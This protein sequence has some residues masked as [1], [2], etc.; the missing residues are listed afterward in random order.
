MRLDKILLLCY[1][2]ANFPKCPD[3]S[4]SDFHGC[5]GKIRFRHAVLLDQEQ[6]MQFSAV[7]Y[8]ATFVNCGIWVLYGLLFVHPHS[9]LVVTINV[10]AFFIETPYLILFLFYSAPKQRL[11]VLLIMVAELVFLGVLATLT[12]TVAHTTKVRSNIVGSIAIVGNIMMYAAPLSVMLKT[13]RRI[14]TKL[15]FKNN[16]FKSTRLLMENKRIGE[17]LDSG[18]FLLWS[19]VFLS[20]EKDNLTTRKGNMSRRLSNVL[21]MTPHQKKSWTVLIQVV[22]NVHVQMSH[23]GKRYKRLISTDTQGMT[24]AT[25]LPLLLLFRHRTRRTDDGCGVMRRTEVVVVA[26]WGGQRRSLFPGE[27]RRLRLDEEDNIG[28]LRVVESSPNWYISPSKACVLLEPSDINENSSLHSDEVK[29]TK[30][31]AMTALCPYKMSG[32]RDYVINGNMYSQH[33]VESAPQT[34]VSKCLQVVNL[35][36]NFI[37]REGRRSVEYIIL[38]DE[39]YNECEKTPSIR[40]MRADSVDHSC[41]CT[42][43]QFNDPNTEIKTTSLEKMKQSWG[44]WVHRP[45]PASRRRLDYMFRAK[46]D[47]TIV[48]RLQLDS[49][50]SIL[51]CEYR[52]RMSRVGSL[53]QSN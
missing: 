8:L 21:G 24:L 42:H 41:P 11:K 45:Q 26:G 18:F 30:D 29:E 1:F 51:K 38:F 2:R 44:P 4:N 33:A 36:V 15:F 14:S 22:E 9:L 37:A 6:W 49:S 40:R 13:W 47:P 12:L 10:T 34:F 19:K 52:H 23:F 27:P 20:F 39:F 35:R 3:G 5:F 50:D 53:I 28:D 31:K 48:K 7:P 32:S 46:W 17:I 43:A 25:V 16:L